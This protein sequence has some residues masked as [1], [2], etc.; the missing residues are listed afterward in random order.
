M[1]TRAIVQLLETGADLSKTIG[2]KITQRTNQSARQ[3]VFDLKDTAGRSGAARQKL[4]TIFCSNAKEPKL[5]VGYD[6][7]DDSY[8]RMNMLFKDGET[9]LSRIE[10][11]KTNG[12]RMDFDINLVSSKNRSKYLNAKGY[13]TPGKKKFDM[14]N[15]CI[16]KREGNPYGQY[17][18]PGFSVEVEAGKGSLLEIAKT[19]CKAFSF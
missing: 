15:W 16:G 17:H 5:E 8:S 1:G 9:P 13:A 11:C 18:I 10:L 6:I 4:K 14:K 19:I 7:T 12:G 2:G 3:V